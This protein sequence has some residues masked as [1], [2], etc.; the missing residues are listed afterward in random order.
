M[1]AFVAI[2]VPSEVVDSLVAFQKELSVAGADIK[3]VEKENLHFTVR[4]LGEITEAQ[5]AAAAARIRHLSLRSADVEV[6]GVGAFPS[7]RRPRVVWAGVAPGHEGLVAPV[8]NGVA[9]ALEGIGENDGR[10]FQAH[11]TLGRVRFVRDPH[12]LAEFI[13]AN[14][15]RPFGT[16][17]L[18]EVKLKSSVLT[19]RGPVY[20]DIEVL[21]LG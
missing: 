2:D 14:A 6:K 5:A 4:F 15:E 16:A 12:A 11:I 10:P 8:A 19:P 7:P 13:Q 17:A 21:K 3:L 1:R 18:K 20:S 9:G